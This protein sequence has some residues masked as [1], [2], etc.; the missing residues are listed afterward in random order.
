MYLRGKIA[1]FLK[2]WK[3]DK[4]RKQLILRGS[5]QVGETDSIN[6]FARQN[7]E[8]IIEINFI[9]DEK[10]KGKRVYTF[11]YSCAFLLK[12]FLPSFRPEKQL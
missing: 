9:R 7:Y 8:S 5:R 4:A 2:N 6:H 3:A 10:Y 11:P 1:F 12:R